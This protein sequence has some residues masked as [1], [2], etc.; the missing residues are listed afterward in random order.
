MART[1]Y[2]VTVKY[3][4]KELT[5][6]ERVQL[7][8]T[9]DCIRL[10]TATQSGNVIIHP[11]FYAELAIHNEKGEDKDY[12]NYVVVDENGDRYLTGSNSFYNSFVD[13]ME[14]MEDSNEEYA[15]K[16]YRVPSKNRQ[17]KDFITC[18]II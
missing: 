14:E 11:D 13:I 8:D 2:S 18:S 6:K 4:S 9:T 7:Q 3:T 5:H 12:I 15:V 1:D 16:C 10:D 17:G